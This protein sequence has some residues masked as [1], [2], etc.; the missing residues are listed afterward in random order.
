MARLRTPGYGGV[1]A[2]TMAEKHVVHA[3]MERRA[4]LAGE[5]RAKQAEVLSLRRALASV[6]L[7]IRMFK[8][9][10]QPASTAPKVTLSKSPAN[11]PKGRGYRTALEILRETGKP[12][13]A[14][15]LAYLALQRLGK[16]P[17]E[18]AITMLAKTIHSSFSRQK[19]PVVTYDRSSS[20][21]GKWRLL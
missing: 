9:D 21:P 16:E 18:P 7:C 14:M 17:M 4:R 8:A 19:I 3:L 13:T 10:Y 11:L 15:E 2:D 12:F 1:G 6:D 5:L 20:W